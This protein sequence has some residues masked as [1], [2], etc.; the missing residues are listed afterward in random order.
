MN[1]D[2]RGTLSLTIAG[3][4]DPINFGIVLNSTS[5]G[6]MMDE[7]S[8][9]SQASTGSG[10]F[11]K[12]TG[13][14][15]AVSSIAG[16]YVFDFAGLDANGAPDSVLGQLD[17]NNGVSTSGFFDKN[18]NFQLANGPLSG[19]F[20]ADTVQLG[21]PISTTGRGVALIGGANFVFYIVDATRVRFISSSG[22]MLSGDAVA[23]SNNV[24]TTVASLNSGFAFLVAGSS[25]NGGVVR[26][27]RFTANGAA[28]TKV[29]Q[30][31]NDAGSFIPTD[32]TTTA[33]VSIDSATPGRGTLTFTDKNFPKA[34]SIYVFYLSSPNQGVIQETTADANGIVNVADGTIAA[35]TGSPFSATNITGK[36]AYS[37]SGVIV[38]PSAID[39]EDLL[40]EATVSNL[41]FA[42]TDDIFQ[43]N[44][45]QPKTDV[46]ASGSIVIAS[47]DGTS[48]DG[49]RNTMS[50][51]YDKNDPSAASVKC[52]V[53]FVNPQLAFFMNNQDKARTVAGVL[54]AQP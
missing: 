14:P 47:S 40:G 32:T 16:P 19:T 38:Q 6:L 26:V 29:L 4:T 23:Q 41:A 9:K 27:G 18:D 17:I 46:A 49:K 31:T 48:A 37:W 43:F 33:S 42:G 30:D 22:G 44:N 28:V 34:P 2:G 52:V 35:Q 3:A 36:Y 7:T 24:P 5:D 11:I 54:Q 10:N 51:I 21:F 1:A 45:L 53:Y 13:G 25:V 39:E 12:Q 15:F 20:G 50:V 8:T